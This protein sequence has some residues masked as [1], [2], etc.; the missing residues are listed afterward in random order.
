MGSVNAVADYHRTTVFD[1]TFILDLA[2]NAY[3]LQIS[4][5]TIDV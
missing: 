2:V 1:D 4:H 3:Y 5:F